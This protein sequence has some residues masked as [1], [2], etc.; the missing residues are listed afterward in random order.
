[1]RFLG[2]RLGRLRRSLR[3]GVL[4]TSTGGNIAVD[5]N[6]ERVQ[7]SARNL[8]DP[9]SE[10]LGQ[11]TINRPTLGYFAYLGTITVNNLIYLRYLRM[12]IFDFD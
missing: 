8:G 7:Q 11:V 10:N 1:M 12:L 5:M 3:W 6:E 2:E 4:G 9:P